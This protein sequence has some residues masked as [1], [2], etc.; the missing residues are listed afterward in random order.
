MSGHVV[1]IVIENTKP[2]IWRI[3]VLPEK[4]QLKTLVGGNLSNLAIQF[5]GKNKMCPL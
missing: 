4:I 3:I 2:P 5:L 1:K